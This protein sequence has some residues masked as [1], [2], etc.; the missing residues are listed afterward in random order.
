MTLLRTSHDGEM[1]LDHTASPGIPAADAERLDM[2]AELVGEGK[3]MT[4]AVMGCPHCGGCQMLNPMRKRP[5][6]VCHKCDKYVCDICAG[7]MRQ[8]GYV[9]RT[10]EEIAAM[11]HSGKWKLMGSMSNPMM[12]PVTEAVDG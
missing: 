11:V 4:A 1:T 10:I 9:H 12:I 8:P 3:K 2:P 7:V 6:N 5:R